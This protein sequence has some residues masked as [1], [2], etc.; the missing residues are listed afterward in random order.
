MGQSKVTISS[1]Y[2][3]LLGITRSYAYLGVQTSSFFSLKIQWLWAIF[4]TKKIICRFQITFFFLCCQV[5]KLHPKKKP[6]RASVSTCINLKL[7]TRICIYCMSK[8]FPND[9][10]MSCEILYFHLGVFQTIVD[11]GSKIWLRRK[12]VKTIRTKWHKSREFCRSPMQCFS[13]EL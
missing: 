9:Q 6:T 4:S 1:F 10:Q 11:R 2:M 8:I 3:A 7:C 13:S 12:E 5:V